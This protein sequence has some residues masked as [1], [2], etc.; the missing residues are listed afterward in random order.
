M[1]IPHSFFDKQTVD[2]HRVEENFAAIANE[3]NHL[4]GSNLSGIP[5]AAVIPNASYSVQAVD[6]TH[7]ANADGERGL[8][9]PNFNPTWFMFAGWAIGGTWRL[10][11][12]DLSIKTYTAG[13]NTTYAE[14]ERNGVTLASTHIEPDAAGLYSEDGFS[15]AF[16]EGDTIE[17]I[18]RTGGA[19]MVGLKVYLHWQMDLA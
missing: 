15:Y 19:Q 5:A 17:V 16:A 2:R 11:Q 12:V 4:G 14:V 3:V 13:L 8:F 1:R 9:D 10:Y 6:C 18:G 7:H